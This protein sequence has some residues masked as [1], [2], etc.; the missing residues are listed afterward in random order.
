L[1]RG[2]YSTQLIYR[3][4]INTPKQKQEESTKC[5]SHAISIEE[6]IRKVNTLT[7]ELLLQP[8]PVEEQSRQ[9]RLMS[10]RLGEPEGFRGGGAETL[11]VM[12]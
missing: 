7:T 1:S 10:R 4:V 11:M 3:T 2:H 8:S 12:V 5:S 6:L 9:R